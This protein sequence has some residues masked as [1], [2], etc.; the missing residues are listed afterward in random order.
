LTINLRNF[1]LN[2][3]V[4]FDALMRD[5]NVTLA[6]K[7][8]NLS[9]SAMSHALNRL[10]ALLDDPILI[11]TNRGMSPTPLA[12][13]IEVP[14]RHALDEIRQSLTISKSFDPRKSKKKFVIYST[15]YFECLILPKLM[16]KLEKMAPGISI[17]SEM[18]TT[19]LP[20]DALNR[21]EASFVVALDDVFDVP[22]R[23]R[24]QHLLKDT[25]VCM[26]RKGNP[27]IG[28]RLSREAYCS[29]RHLYH[30][31]LGTPFNYSLM[32]GWLEANHLKRD[33][34]FTAIGFMTATLVLE[35]TDCVMTLPRRLAFKFVEKMNL[36]I[37]QP[38]KD[39]PEF[40]LN[41]IWHPLFEKEPSNIWM[42][43]QL[44][45]IVQNLD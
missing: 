14:L 44:T 23:L 8:V 16:A 5:R 42:R 32:D 43:R 33:F 45:K 26:T 10:R 6:A 41:L 24:S 7:R 25:L 22:S 35:E 28:D 27:L 13:D 11:S 15:G 38:P 37:V 40:Q 21:G 18:L 12:L 39:F 4:V 19:E 30:S 29:A 2:L 31:T 3:L 17:V 1:D 34:A 20:E 36:K 9:Q